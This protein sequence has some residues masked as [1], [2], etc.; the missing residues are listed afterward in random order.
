MRVHTHHDTLHQHCHSHN[1]W[2]PWNSF[3][4]F[5]VPVYY[6]KTVEKPE[7]DPQLSWE[8]QYD[9]A[10]LASV[11]ICAKAY[12]PCFRSR[13]E[14]TA[15]WIFCDAH[16]C[17]GHAIARNDKENSTRCCYARVLC[18]SYDHIYQETQKLC[19]SAFSCAHVH[20]PM[21]ASE[22]HARMN[23]ALVHRALHACSWYAYSM[24][25][26]CFLCVLERIL[27]GD[28]HAH[29]P[30]SCCRDEIQI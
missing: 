3:R 9:K 30:S 1:N 27:T 8:W 25:R 16:A 22:G 11:C 24:Q 21:S 28:I 10:P 2:G 26:A 5:L 19:F 13:C 15:I 29:D 18:P 4:R 20:V 12:S 6:W 17:K 14:N 7:T 23:G